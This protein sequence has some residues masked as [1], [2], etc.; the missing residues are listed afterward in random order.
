MNNHFK[1][2]FW[3]AFFLLMSIAYLIP[4]IIFNAQLV[5]LVGLGTPQEHDLEQLEVFGRAISGLGVTLLIADL[6]PK[7]FYKTRLRGFTSIGLLTCVT[8]PTVY[9]GQKLLIERYL[10][11][12]STAE[13]REYAVLSAAFRDALAVN[14]VTV[15][16]LEYDNEVLKSP[17]NLTFLAIFGGLLYADDTLAENLES[18]KK[19]IIKQFVQKR[20]YQDLDMY[21]DDFSSIYEKLSNHYTYYAEGS[22]KYNK[23][24]AEIP[25]QEQVYW[26]EIEQEINQGWQQY[27]QA[28]KTYIARAETRAQ[29]YGP[30]VYTYHQEVN[31][32]REYYEKHSERDRR[33]G[34]IEKLN[35]AYKA[36]IDSAGLGYIPP[37]YWLIEEDISGL[38][39]AASSILAGVLTGGLFTAL[40]A[41][42][43]ATGG[44]G[45]MKEKRYKYTDDPMHYQTRI[46]AHPNFHKQFK[47]D[48]GYPM[49]ISSLAVFRSHNKTQQRI[50][51]SLSKR[52]L[53]LPKNWHIGQRLQFAQAVADKV[54][55][56]ADRQW[57]NK[58]QQKKFDLPVNLDWQSF[59]LHPNIQNKIA[60]QMGEMYVKNTKPDWNKKNFKHYVLDPNIEKRTQQY[61]DMVVGARVH[62]ENGGKYAAAGKQALRSV[63]IPPISMSLSLFLICFTI[64]KLPIK[65]LEV[66]KP[67]WSTPPPS[68]TVATVK[69]LPLALLIM[70]PVILLEN[71]FTNNTHSPVNY[72]LYKVESASNPIFSFAL[73]WTLHVQPFLHPVG[74]KLESDT[75]F[76]QYVK[77]YTHLLALLD[78]RLP[79]SSVTIT[80]NEVIKR[81]STAALYLRIQANIENTTI[82]IMNIKPKY[83]DNMKLQP[84]N[85]DI[86]VTAPGFKPYRRW[87][88]LPAGEH[89]ISIEMQEMR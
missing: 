81:V 59:Q 44:D 14:A 43:L 72:F 15:V 56:D 23:A 9:F 51:D 85:Y 77:P 55:A 12:P 82:R 8:W 19:S 48:I 11:E 74:V 20:T 42:D 65:T 50:L 35:A 10:I 18:H 27:Q 28:I 53:E 30:K 79:K 57:R 66:F 84:G 64:I 87:H 61:L 49:G 36:E 13:Q 1:P 68:Y 4:E 47:K 32:C 70:L 54:K 88:T 60:E 34:C 22:N 29:K 26:Q 6:L 78:A 41:A 5:S 38:E 33:T 86:Q 3:R 45:G 76:Y 69:I 63:I 2:T 21:Y 37:N 25:E 31:K 24:L 40:Q 71:R 52:G 46:L 16:G 39:N 80:P 89:T 7:S 75:Q 62:F 58:M 17:E 83:I 67:N 73:R